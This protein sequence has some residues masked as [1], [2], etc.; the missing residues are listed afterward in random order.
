[1]RASLC[2]LG[3]GLL[4]CV[5]NIGDAPPLDPAFADGDGPGGSKSQTDEW[6]FPAGEAS[7]TMRRLSRRELGNAVE[8]LIGVRPDA[9][10]D[11]SPDKDDL[12]YDRVVEAQT[13]SALHEEGF[14][15]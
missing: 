2:V 10:G 15:K 13:V 11:Q 6:S 12:V 9:L 8:A 1:M 4:G 5:G 7:V 3:L 14:A